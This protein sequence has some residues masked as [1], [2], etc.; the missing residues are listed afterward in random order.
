MSTAALLKQLQCPKTALLSAMT[1]VP[2]FEEMVRNNHVALG[3]VGAHRQLD[4]HDRA[5]HALPHPRLRHQQQQARGSAGRL[6]ATTTTTGGGGGCRGWQR[7]RCIRADADMA[8]CRGVG[9]RLRARGSKPIARLAFAGI[10]RSL[11]RSACACAYWSRS[12]S[13]ERA[14]QL[15]IQPGLDFRVQLEPAAWH[16]LVE[17]AG[18]VVA[19]DGVVHLRRVGARRVARCSR[20]ANEAGQAHEWRRQEY[21]NSAAVRH[22]TTGLQARKAGVSRAHSL[23]VNEGRHLP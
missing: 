5:E 8:G 10:P 20:Q 15:S 9:V 4:V 18:H 21:A 6:A 23:P 22:S 19:A 7:R 12:G 1:P 17:Q 13:R 14:C 16:V 2:H 11:R 3:P